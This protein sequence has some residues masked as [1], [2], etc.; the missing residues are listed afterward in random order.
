MLDPADRPQTRA[1]ISHSYEYSLAT[2]TGFP[3]KTASLP[4][5]K[6]ISEPKISYLIL[7]EYFVN[8]ERHIFVHIKLFPKYYTA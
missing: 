8:F 1:G 7:W 5:V 3:E 6:K 2:T 4:V